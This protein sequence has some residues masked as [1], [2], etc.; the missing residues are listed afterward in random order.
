MLTFADEEFGIQNIELMYSIRLTSL[1]LLSL[2]STLLRLLSAAMPPAGR[3]VS[4]SAGLAVCRQCSDGSR[5]RIPDASSPYCLLGGMPQH[6]VY[7]VP[8]SS[9]HRSKPCCCLAVLGSMHQ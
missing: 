2:P 4:T 6:S 3:P 8:W 1:L 7:D 5:C 9:E